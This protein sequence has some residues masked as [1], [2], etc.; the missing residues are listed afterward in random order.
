MRWW[1]V[2]QHA[3]GECTNSRGNASSGAINNNV[4]SDSGIGQPR[5][6]WFDD[7]DCACG[8]EP[9]AIASGSESSAFACGYT[10]ADSLG[11]SAVGRGTWTCSIA[12]IRCSRCA[13][14]C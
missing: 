4:E 9:I 1:R 6:G 12:S 3:D 8:L 14:K 10:R 11:C 2:R 7:S 13:R 5:A